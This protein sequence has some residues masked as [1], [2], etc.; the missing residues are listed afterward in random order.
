MD[1]K[2]YA[3][4]ENTW[5]RLMIENN[6]KCPNCGYE[7]NESDSKLICMNCGRSLTSNKELDNIYPQDISNKDEKT[8]NVFLSMGMIW[9]ALLIVGGIIS[10]VTSL[11]LLFDIL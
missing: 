8:S 6:R 11:V 3:V 1:R 10:A 7:L 5:N 9:W 4:D 2:V